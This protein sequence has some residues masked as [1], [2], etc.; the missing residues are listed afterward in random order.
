[1]AEKILDPAFLAVGPRTTYTDA[2]AVQF[3]GADQRT[4]FQPVQFLEAGQ[5]RLTP[6]PG[7]EQVA[8]TAHSADPLDMGA[9]W[10]RPEKRSCLTVS[11]ASVG[12]GSHLDV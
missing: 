2:L 7:L 5:G 1:M 3:S 11:M 10:I 6:R 12:R 4:H 9:P 8:A